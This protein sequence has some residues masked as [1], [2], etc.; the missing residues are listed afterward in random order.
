M[1]LRRTLLWVIVCKHKRMCAL[2]YSVVFPG[3]PPSVFQSEK[4]LEEV[5]YISLLGVA[6]LFWGP[7][8]RELGLRLQLGLMDHCLPQVQPPPLHWKQ[9]LNDS[10]AGRHGSVLAM[11]W[12]ST[13]SMDGPYA[14]VYQCLLISWC[15]NLFRVGSVAMTSK[16]KTCK[17]A[18]IYRS[19]ILQTSP[20]L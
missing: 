18:M 20:P 12:G 14:F 5:S 19:T 9:M 13:C 7:Q 16:R 10:P 4:L 11:K 3:S 8:F 15:G 6:S 17:T 2:S 1:W